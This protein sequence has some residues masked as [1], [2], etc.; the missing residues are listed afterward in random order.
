MLSSNSDSFTSSIPIWIPLISF[1]CLTAVARMANTMLNKSVKSGYS[2]L[3]PGLI[4]NSFSFSALNMMLA[5][6]L[7]YTAFIML[8]YVPSVSTL[9]RIFS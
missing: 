1:S 5:V 7:S 9:L 4:G 6:G 3:V 8:R 2:C